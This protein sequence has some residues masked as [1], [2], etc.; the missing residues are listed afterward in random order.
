MK[1]FDKELGE[2]LLLETN[3]EQE[4]E[5]RTKKFEDILV[6][7]LFDSYPIEA[8]YELIRVFDAPEGAI[9]VKGLIKLALNKVCVSLKQL[10]AEEKSEKS[11]KD[12]NKTHLDKLQVL[13]DSISSHLNRDDFKDESSSN[14]KKSK[15]SK[16]PKSEK[17]ASQGAKIITD[18][19]V[20]ECM[21]AFCNDHQIDINIRLLILEELK[22]SIK[23]I[24]DEDLM[25]LLV[26]KTN[27]ILANCDRFEKKV[28]L[29]D[30]TDI[31]NEHQRKILIEKLIDLSKSY[32]HYTAL[33]SLLKSWPEFTVESASEK[34]WIRVLLKLVWGNHSII[35]LGNE[36]KEKNILKETDL[37]YIKHE[38]EAD[39]NWTDPDGL[40][41]ISFMKLMFLFKNFKSVRAFV[42]SVD[43]ECFSLINKVN[44]ASLESFSSLDTILNDKELAD[45]MMLDK[46]YVQLI[47]TP[48]YAI[49]SSYVLKNETKA[50]LSDIVKTLRQNG[51]NVEAA[52]LLVEVEN[53]NDCYRTLS[54]SLSL[55]ERFFGK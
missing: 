2:V 37:E 32:A 41:K 31:E 29:V 55:M 18:E 52:K 35:E 13:L 39:D 24:K 53:L 17:Q 25:I 50:T 49:F 51:H 48:L 7:M 47:N 10:K 15:K 46:A 28:E 20:M 38:L 45:L 42:D 36:L 19:D 4:Q 9:S 30:S 33:I 44:P 3:A 6:N 5:I 22:K 54:I 27:A 23:H 34:P 40:M 21:R 8:L 14:S 12:K 11:L 1:Q 26:H 43:L 16:E